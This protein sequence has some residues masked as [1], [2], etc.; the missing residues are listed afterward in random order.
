MRLAAP[1][2]FEALEQRPPRRR[3]RGAPAAGPDSAAGAA[4]AIPPLAAPPTE[5]APALD[6]A[7]ALD[8]AANFEFLPH[9]ADVLCHGWGCDLRVALA[10]VVLGLNAYQIYEDDLSTVVARRA[11]Q[12]E[13]TGHDLLSLVYALLDN[14]N[15]VFSQGLVS[16]ACRVDAITKTT[17]SSPPVAAGTTPPP[18]T[19]WKTTATLFGETYQPLGVHGQGTEIKAITYS[20]MR[21]EDLSKTNA[22]VMAS[23]GTLSEH[24]EGVGVHVSV[25][26]DI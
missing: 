24:Q 19:T 6:M 3:R 22:D 11:H 8:G 15:F 26:F 17:A 14:A 20:A 21:I 4:A 1:L 18:T 5:A 10:A 2:T 16:R 12:I 25:V 7:G 9:T 23:T 13:A